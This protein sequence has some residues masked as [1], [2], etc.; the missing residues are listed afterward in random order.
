M[1]TT[2]LKECTDFGA[3]ERSNL[4]LRFAMPE[5]YHKNFKRALFDTQ[6][7]WP[8]VKAVVIW[9]EMSVP[10]C[11]WSAKVVRDML[12]AQP[13]EGSTEVRR[14]IH[15]QNLEGADHFVSIINTSAPLFVF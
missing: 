6:G 11:V 2:E 7:V 10:D 15:I 14:E 1:S 5:V 9:G 8:N 4:S 12:A 3:L 13:E